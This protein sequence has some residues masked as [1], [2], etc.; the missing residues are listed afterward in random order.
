MWLRARV[1]IDLSGATK[2][3]RIDR[4]VYLCRTIVWVST[5]ALESGQ[6]VSPTVQVLLNRHGERSDCVGTLTSRSCETYHSFPHHPHRFICL[7]PSLAQARDMSLLVTQSWWNASLSSFVCD[8]KTKAHCA[9]KY[10]TVVKRSRLR[11]T[12]QGLGFWTKV[13]VAL[14]LGQH[15]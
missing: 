3:L 15:G 5:C 2:L 11:S 7:L 14:A 1:R 6:C 10:S 4:F 8:A 12:V 9:Y 13:F